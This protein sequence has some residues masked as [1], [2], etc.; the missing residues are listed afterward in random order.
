MAPR[1][2]EEVSEPRVSCRLA[3]GVCITFSGAEAPSVGTAPPEPDQ[4]DRA[5]YY[6]RFKEVA[7]FSGPAEASAESQVLL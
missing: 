3:G 7:R 2:V 5:H 6:D 4:T 1:P